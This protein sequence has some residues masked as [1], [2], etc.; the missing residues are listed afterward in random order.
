MRE[1][2]HSFAIPAFV[3]GEPRMYTMDLIEKSTGVSFQYKRHILGGGIAPMQLTAPVGSMGTG[4]SALETDRFYARRLLGVVNAYN[5]E[6][7][8]ASAVS[9]QFAK[10]C[11]FAHQLTTDGTVGP[12]CIVV[13]RNSKTSRYKGGG[14]TFYEATK[15]V[16]G[17]VLP[18]VSV[19]MGVDVSAIEASMLMLFY[20]RVV[21][22]FGALERGGD[23][24][25][26]SITREEIE[27]QLSKLP[28]DPDD[29][30]R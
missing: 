5:Q 6:K 1:R 14:Q 13:W 27:E 25:L 16:D 20:P 9:A 2:Q 22:Y 23:V 19:G 24:Q 15:E 17:G 12:S 4:R 28:H 10:L 11:Y 18:T 29:E 8:S 26:P 30:L 3:D 21:E 7:V